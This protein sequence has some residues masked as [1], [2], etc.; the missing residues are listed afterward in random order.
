[1]SISL[2][3][4]LVLPFFFAAVVLFR[5]E[6]PFPRVF[7]VVA[8]VLMF[9]SVDNYLLGKG[10]RSRLSTRLS[11]SL[12]S[13]TSRSGDCSCTSLFSSL[14]PLSGICFFWPCSGL[15]VGSVCGLLGLRSISR[16]GISSGMS[17]FSFGGAAGSR[18]SLGWPSPSP[19]FPCPS[20]PG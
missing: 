17:G 14:S 4:F 7:F 1:F 5:E 12:S 15:F 10:K 20:L 3:T 19:R 2:L 6:L 16:F 8:I 11:V 9:Y 13:S 18:P